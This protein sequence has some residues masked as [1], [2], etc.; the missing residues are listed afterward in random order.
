[1]ERNMRLKYLNIV[2]WI[3]EN[4]KKGKLSSEEKLPTEFEFAEMFEC[5]RYTVRRALDHLERMGLIYRIQGNGSYLVDDIDSLIEKKKRSSRSNVVGVIITN[6]KTHIFSSIITGI[7]DYLVERGYSICLLVTDNDF[8]K[9]HHSIQKMFDLEPAGVILEPAGSSLSLYNE[10]IYNKL[11]HKIPAIVL[12]GSG[13]ETLPLLSLEDRY[14]TR[15]LVRHLVENGHKDIGC[16]YCIDEQTSKKRYNGFLD[17]MYCNNLNIDINNHLWINRNSLNVLFQPDGN[18]PLNRML[19]KVTAVVCHDD[20]IA[21]GLI[22]Y[23]KENK[24]RVPEDFSIVGYDD[25]D[26]SEYNITTVTH[27]KERY[28][29]KAAEALLDLIENHNNFDIDKYI[30]MPELIKKGSV[31]RHIEK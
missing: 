31:S 25:T 15:L 28:G 24:I 1:M 30:I 2:D 5:S 9:E 29:E 10:K 13:V 4:T 14:G 16:I 11:L 21:Y 3:I 26:T 23:L 18:Y 12:H 7:S 27:P 8:K 20:R 6:N 19:R 17:E 22:H